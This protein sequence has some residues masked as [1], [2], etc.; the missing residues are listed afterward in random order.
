[1]STVKLA[2]VSPPTVPY[3]FEL[4]AVRIHRVSL[5]PSGSLVQVYARS[6]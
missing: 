4:A 6:E 2:M 5:R 1:L 3:S